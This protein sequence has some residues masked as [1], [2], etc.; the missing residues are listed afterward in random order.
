VPYKG[1]YD[2][3]KE[4]EALRQK[5]IQ[6]DWEKQE[7]RLKE[8][9]AKGITKQNAEKEQLKSKG[10][11]PGARA[12]KLEAQQAS[13]GGPESGE[14][15]IELIKRPKEY[16]VEFGFPEVVKISPPILEVRDVGFRYS[17]AHPRLFQNVNFGIGT[18]PSFWS[19][20]S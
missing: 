2:N 13:S 3:F 12:K 8:L 11:E 19:L 7:K 9:K 6:K 4:Q 5:T 20:A 10:R 18:H 15:K 16:S 17:A 14:S 1:N